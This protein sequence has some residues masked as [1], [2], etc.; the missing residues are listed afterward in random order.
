MLGTKI[1][2][3]SPDIYFS[4]IWENKGTG[5]RR[6]AEIEKR[7]KLKAGPTPEERD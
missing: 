4:P 5:K 7:R 1:I 2:Q 3:R 6:T